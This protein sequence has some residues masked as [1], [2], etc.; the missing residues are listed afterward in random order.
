MQERDDKR[1][2]RQERRQK[3]RK[4]N[5]LARRKLKEALQDNPTEAHWTEVDFGP[6][7]V[8]KKK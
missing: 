5:K 8:K 1:K 6:F 4:G 3:K 2:L 7:Q